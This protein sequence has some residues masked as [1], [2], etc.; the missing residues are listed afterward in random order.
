MRELLAM[1]KPLTAQVRSPQHLARDDKTLLAE[2]MIR[3]L[4]ADP[5]TSKAATSL[6]QPSPDYD[7]LAFTSAIVIN[8][9]SG[10]S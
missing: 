3:M 4:Q 2:P 6:N 10:V 9:L 5:L 8:N 1:D 7:K